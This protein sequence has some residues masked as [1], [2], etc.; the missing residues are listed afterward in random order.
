MTDRHSGYLVILA[1]DVRED[2]AE[3]TVRVA[4]SMIKG[5]QSVRPI[6]AGSSKSGNEQL[7]AEVRTTK[8][9]SDAIDLLL[10]LGPARILE[11]KP[12]D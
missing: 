3:E 8:L 9:W 12:Q 7:I 2:D 1:N 10:K 4:L 5:V 11:L 6:V